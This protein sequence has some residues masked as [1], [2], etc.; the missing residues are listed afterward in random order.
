MLGG[1]PPQVV[2]WVTSGV[3]HKPVTQALVILLGAWSRLLSVLDMSDKLTQSAAGAPHCLK[4]EQACWVLVTALA[5]PTCKY[6][7]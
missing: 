1:M 7:V 3:L 6:I 4:V 2:V 5:V